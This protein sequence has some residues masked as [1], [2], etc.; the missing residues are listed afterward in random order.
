[1]SIIQFMHL[2]SMHFWTYLSGAHDLEPLSLI[3]SLGV[4]S[5]N[6]DQHQISP[7]NINSY[8]TLEVMKIKDM[9]TEGE[10]S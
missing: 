1:M 4:E 7:C 5:P 2:I 3:L 9:I 10:F 6:S 8:S